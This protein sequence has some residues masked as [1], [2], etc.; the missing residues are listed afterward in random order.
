MEESSTMMLGSV[1]PVI[2]APA[3]IASRKAETFGIEVEDVG[4]RR[5]I[6]CRPS[7][8]VVIAAVGGSGGASRALH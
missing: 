7:G 4:P 5:L 8:A 3:P 6:S 2:E 1:H